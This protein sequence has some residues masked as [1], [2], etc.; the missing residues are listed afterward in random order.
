MVVNNI[1]EH[2]MYTGLSE[3]E[4]RIYVALLRRSP[5][6]AYETAKNAGVPTSK[7]YEIM[8]RLEEKSIVNRVGEG[9]TVKYA[10]LNPGEFVETR[11]TMMQATLDLLKSELPSMRTEP[12]VSYIWNI[13]S[14]MDLLERT[15]ALITSASKT[16]LLS[17]WPEEA[18]ELR[19]DLDEAIQRGVRVASVH[20][21]LVRGSSLPGQVY[22]HPIQDTIYTEKGGRGLCIVAD[23]FSALMGTITATGGASGAYSTSTGFVTLAEDYIKHDIYVMK[24]V[25]RYDREMLERFGPHYELLR[26]VFSDEEKGA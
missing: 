21:G 3:Y 24:M 6:T 8:A 14:Y 17:I 5:A 13:T 23:T 4:A 19:A 1:I 26:D 18:Q 10:P 2:L 12:E 7:V 9:K 20:F 22:V 25:K 16:I 15:R 11:R